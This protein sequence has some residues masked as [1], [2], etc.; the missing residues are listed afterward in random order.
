MTCDVMDQVTDDV[1]TIVTHDL[2]RYCDVYHRLRHESDVLR[3]EW[4]EDGS[5]AENEGFS[6]S[7]QGQIG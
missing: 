7:C 1:T 6:K 3:L 5:R 2:L 4:L